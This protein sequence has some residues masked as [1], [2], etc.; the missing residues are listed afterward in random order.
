MRHLVTLSVIACLL[1]LACSKRDPDQPASEKEFKPIGEDALI[2]KWVCT[3][4]LGTEVN[5][6]GYFTWEFR[7]DRSLVQDY[8]PDQSN[9]DHTFG[10]ALGSYENRESLLLMDISPGPGGMINEFNQSVLRLDG[11]ELTLWLPGRTDEGRL[12]YPGDMLFKFRRK[13][14]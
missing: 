3:F 12:D 1:S 7:D 9:Q 11:D 4:R 14:P 6:T 10:W 2:G 13:L 5:D 8:P